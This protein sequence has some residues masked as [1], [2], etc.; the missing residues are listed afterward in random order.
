[1]GSNERYTEKKCVLAMDDLLDQFLNLRKNTST[2]TDYMSQFEA[3]MLRYEIDEEQRLLVYGFVNDL[4]A[5][6]KREVK[7]HPL[8]SLD[9]AYQKVLDYEKYLRVILAC[10]S[11]NPD[12]RPS[13]SS[14]FLR[15]HS[16]THLLTLHH[17]LQLV[18]YQ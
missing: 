2:V 8:Y 10:V 7:V 1:M 11:F 13:R 18:R 14:I 5:D 17:H 16:S 12:I 4:R 3:L 15:S 9:A 6:I